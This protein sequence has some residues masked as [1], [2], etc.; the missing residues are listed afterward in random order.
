MKIFQCLAKNRG[1]KRKERDEG[2]G[3][4]WEEKLKKLSFQV[5]TLHE[6]K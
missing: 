5:F 2:R 6:G 4:R 3:E 1:S